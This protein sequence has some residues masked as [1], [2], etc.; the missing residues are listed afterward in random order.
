MCWWRYWF[1]DNHYSPL[2]SYSASLEI[3]IS[4]LKLLEF[5]DFFLA[6]LIN[7][8]LQTEHGFLVEYCWGQWV[9]PNPQN[10][11]KLLPWPLL[12]PF[13]STSLWD[14]NGP[15]WNIIGQWLVFSIQWTTNQTD[16]GTLYKFKDGSLLWVPLTTIN[17]FNKNVFIVPKLFKH[18]CQPEV[19]FSP[20]KKFTDYKK[21]F[22]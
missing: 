20:R 11:V 6:P 15:W 13:W 16:P 22:H 4:L 8:S 18:W 3:H 14:R 5:S 2:Q 10:V 17:L 21:A 7:L 9:N 12:Q 1:F 19:F